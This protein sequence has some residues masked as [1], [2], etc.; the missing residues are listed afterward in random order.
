MSAEKPEYWG[1]LEQERLTAKSEED[2]V[3]EFC[4]AW[5]SEDPI[6][7][8][9]VIYGY[10]PE[11]ININRLA[12]DTLEHVLEYLDEEYGD[13]DNDP[14]GP[15]DKMKLAAQDFISKV[16]EDYHVFKCKPV[17]KK[18]VKILDYVS[19]KDLKDMG[20]TM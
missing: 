20:I 12:E 19:E 4:E 18:T 17:C 3:K 8:E 5:E 13:W 16:A 2:C 7:S 14:D 6:P 15:T 10:D 9:I 1:M 11:T